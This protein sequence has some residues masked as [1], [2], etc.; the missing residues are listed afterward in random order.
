MA[1]SYVMCDDAAPEQWRKEID[2]EPAD[3]CDGARTVNMF[4]GTHALQASRAH[5]NARQQCIV[6]V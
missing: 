2:P 5:Q 4:D 1:A 6:S 3:H